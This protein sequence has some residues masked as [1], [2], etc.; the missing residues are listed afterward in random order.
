[1]PYAAPL[2]DMRFTIDTV[3]GLSGEAAEAE[4]VLNEEDR[5]AFR[6]ERD[7]LAW[8]AHAW[9][10]EQIHRIRSEFFTSFGS[11]SFVEPIEDLEALG[12]L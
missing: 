7:C 11:C 4:Q 1:M 5:A 2:A 9:T 10:G 12:W 6:M 8:R 3:A